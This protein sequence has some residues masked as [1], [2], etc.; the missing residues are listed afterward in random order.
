MLAD[1]EPAV[2]R[3]VSPAE[4]LA[5]FK[6]IFSL[7]AAPDALC[8]SGHASTELA[9]MRAVTGDRPSRPHLCGCGC[10]AGLDP[11]GAAP[12]IISCP[13]RDYRPRSAQSAC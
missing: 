11:K 1:C 13:E 10:Q 3:C 4:S 9:R 5:R 12:L 2:Y 8:R 6:L 7:A